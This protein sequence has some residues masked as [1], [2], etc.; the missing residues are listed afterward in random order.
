MALIGTLVDRLLKAGS[1]TLVMPDGT[2]STHGPGGEPHLTLHFADTR[3]GFDIL[4]NPRLGLGEA[5]MDGRITIEGGTILDLLLLVTGSNRWEDSSGGRKL[6]GKGRLGALKALFRHND[7]RK[8]KR[9]VAP[10]C[11]LFSAQIRPSCAV[12]IERAIDRP[13]P[14]PSSL[15]E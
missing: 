11:K 2:R 7:P 9:N 13:N 12:M 5:Y 10:P 4:R 8:A 6:F 3:V 15:V 1:L 14:R